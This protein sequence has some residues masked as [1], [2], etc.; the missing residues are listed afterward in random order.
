MCFNFSHET[1]FISDIL[2]MAKNT[3]NIAAKITNAAYSGKNS[4]RNNAAVEVRVW[5]YDP[6]KNRMVLIKKRGIAQNA[7]DV[8][9]LNGLYNVN[10]NLNNDSWNWRLNMNGPRK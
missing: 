10:N 1:I 3:N 2:Q 6:R 7:E 4:N 9:N 5:R 8:L